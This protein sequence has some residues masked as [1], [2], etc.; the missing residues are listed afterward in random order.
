MASHRGEQSSNE[1]L[2][3]SSDALRRLLE[4]KE[5]EADQ[6]LLQELAARRLQLTFQESL[7]E[8][9]G[10]VTDLYE[11]GTLL[12][13]EFRR[14]LGGKDLILGVVT[15][16]Q[17][18]EVVASTSA[19]PSRYGLELM[20]EAFVVGETLS[21]T[22]EDAGL[23]QSP[24]ATD[25]PEGVPLLAVPLFK[26]DNTPLGVLFVEGSLTEDRVD[27]LTGTLELMA[28]ALEDCLHY[29]RIEQLIEDAVIAIAL[30][31]EAQTPQQDGH[32]Q[33]VADVCRQLS[34]ALDLGPTMT[35]HVRLM[36]LVHDM[37]PDAVAKAFSAIRRAKE[38]AVEWQGLMADPFV[39]GIFP[40][41]LANFQ[42]VLDDLR[43]L[44]CRWDGKGN[45]PAVVGQEIPLAAR[46]VAVSEAFDHLTGGRKHRTTLPIPEAVAQLQVQSGKLY[47]PEVVAELARLYAKVEMAVWITPYPQ[48]DA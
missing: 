24:G 31:N 45:Q 30:E 16:T 39:G 37:G 36:A 35:K 21:A 42:R 13:D 25:M 6:R 1:T 15:E 2:M 33:R 14:N 4:E 43:Y 38:T 5:R 34:L 32:S 26:V 8:K 46:I 7:T 29:C 27:W 44:H 9:M 10:R 3:I 23:L 28:L 17:F 19:I 48:T 41:P 20:E 18:L 47:D 11:L 22:G 12:L 40:S